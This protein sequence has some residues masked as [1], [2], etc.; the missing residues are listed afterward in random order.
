MHGTGSQDADYLLISVEEIQEVAMSD[1]WR[2]S[3]GRLDDMRRHR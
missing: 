3:I 1:H 2:A